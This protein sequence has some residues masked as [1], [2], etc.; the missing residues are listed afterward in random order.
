MH[1]NSIVDETLAENAFDGFA[2]HVGEEVESR[3]Y[4]EPRQEPAVTR[5]TC[6]LR[7]GLFGRG[8]SAAHLWRRRRRLGRRLSTAFSSTSTAAHDLPIVVSN[9]ELTSFFC[10]YVVYGGSSGSCRWSYR[11]YWV[12]WLWRRALGDRFGNRLASS[13]R[14]HNRNFHS[15]LLASSYNAF[16]A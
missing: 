15:N 14:W 9:R 11:L 5:V 4:G 13:R 16:L 1:C 8:L 7:L 12:G 10:I 6:F 3:A 2:L